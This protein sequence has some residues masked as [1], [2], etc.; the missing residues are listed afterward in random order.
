[1][2]LCSLQ[3][4]YLTMFYY[5]KKGLLILQRHSAGG[6][7]WRVPYVTRQYCAFVLAGDISTRQHCAPTT[8]L[9]G[10]SYMCQQSIFHVSAQIVFGLVRHTQ[11]GVLIS[12][13]YQGKQL[14]V[15]WKDSLTHNDAKK[16]KLQ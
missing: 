5:F 7:C 6:L 11:K 10:D 2:E 3:L 9:A 14:A 8:M 15:Q 16:I 1:M 12:D 4:F 13:S